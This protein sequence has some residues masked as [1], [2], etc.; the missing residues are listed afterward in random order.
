MGKPRDGKEV[1]T[2]VSV[3][4][5]PATY[6]ELVKHFGSFT[7]FVKWGIKKFKEEKGGKND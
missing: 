2:A 5:E 6:L 4:I 7:D 1:K 3:R